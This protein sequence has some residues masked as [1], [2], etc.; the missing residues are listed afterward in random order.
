MIKTIILTALLITFLGC[1]GGS[2][3]QATPPVTTPVIAPYTDP[4]TVDW[5]FPNT[6]GNSVASNL[7][8]WQD[9]LLDVSNPSQG[10]ALYI[11]I[12]FIIKNTDLDNNIYCNISPSNKATEYNNYLFLTFQN[13]FIATPDGLT[14]N[15]IVST[16]YSGQGYNNATFIKPIPG[17]YEWDI[18]FYRQNATGIRTP[19]FS[20]TKHITVQVN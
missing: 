15:L 1:S 17:C 11:N 8:I 14:G 4:V 16:R 20:I 3:S 9:P 7:I 18:T 19:Q 2:S 6:D 5:T 12:P 10:I 13:N